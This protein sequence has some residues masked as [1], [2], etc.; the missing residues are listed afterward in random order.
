MSPFAGITSAALVGGALVV[1]GVSMPVSIGL[2][3]IA[4]GIQRVVL[5]CIEVFS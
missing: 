1:A 5:T 2:A 3:C 4:Y